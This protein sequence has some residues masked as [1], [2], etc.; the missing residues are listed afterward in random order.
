MTIQSIEKISVLGAGVLG[1]QIAWHSAYKGKTAV[2]YDISEEALEACRHAHLQYAAIY[3]EDLGATEAEMDATRSR[4]S[5]TLDMKEAAQVDLVIE[6]VPEVPAIKTS[7]YEQ[8]SPLLQSHTIIASNSSTLLP[9]RFAEVTGR[10]QQFCALHFANLLWIMNLVEV[11]SHATTAESTLSAV[12]TFAIE[13]GMVPIPVQKEQNGYVLN[14]WFVPLTNAAQS[15]ITNGVSTAE[16]IDRTYMIAN[17][18]CTMG[19][20]AL[21]DT[22]GMNTAYDVLNYWGT[23]NDDKQMLANANYIKE[24]FIDKDLMGMQGGEGHYKYPNPAYE[25]ADFLAVPD[26]SMVP[27]IVRLAKPDQDS[28]L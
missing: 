11:M 23:L 6:S 8:L 21:M 19:P 10:P 2:V 28:G 20:C 13:I 22:V 4:I 9:K 5:F 27:E 3:M 26:I 15:L 12:T 16:Y 18:G 1:G 24:H 7:V 14:S 17:R 25:A